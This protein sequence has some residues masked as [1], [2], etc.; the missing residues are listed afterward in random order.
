MQICP[1]ERRDVHLAVTQ[2]EID[3][4]GIVQARNLGF[5]THMLC[6]NRK[7]DQK[8]LEDMLPEKENIQFIKMV[9]ACQ[10][11]V[12]GKLLPLHNWAELTSED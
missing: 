7:G 9:S 3:F 1:R 8:P 6:C 5:E 11:P 12:L 10:W 4:K 2:T